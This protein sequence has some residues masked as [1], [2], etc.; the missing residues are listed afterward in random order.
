MRHPDC[1]GVSNTDK[2]FVV[3]EQVA[4]ESLQARGARGLGARGGG[5]AGWS[6]WLALAPVGVCADVCRMK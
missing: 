1:G 3:S 6:V 4:L 2:E 5:D